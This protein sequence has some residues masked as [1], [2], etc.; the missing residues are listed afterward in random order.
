MAE[1]SNSRLLYLL[2]NRSELWR[3]PQA[4][5]WYVENL[6]EWGKERFYEC[7]N[8]ARSRTDPDQ[9]VVLD[10]DQ[11]LNFIMRSFFEPMKGI[12]GE[13]SV[14]G[15]TILLN[16]K[17]D[18]GVQLI[19]K[20]DRGTREGKLR[21]ALTYHEYKAGLRINRLR[22]IYPN[23]VHT[24]RLFSIPRPLIVPGYSR[25]QFL[26]HNVFA[27]YTEK[28]LIPVLVQEYVNDHNSSTLRHYI[29]T[30]SLEMYIQVVHQMLQLC[31]LLT[32]EDIVHGDLHA[33]NILVQSESIC[34]STSFLEPTDYSM[35]CRII[36]YGGMVWKDEDG[37]VAPPRGQ[38]IPS[39]KKLI[40][41][42]DI[43]RLL[44]SMYSVIEF[45]L[46][47]MHKRR[48]KSAV[49]VKKLLKRKSEI[50]EEVFRLIYPGEDLAEVIAGEKKL[51][52]DDK[53]PESD[54]EWVLE[55]IKKIYRA[56][57]R[58]GRQINDY[59]QRCIGYLDQLMDKN[60]ELTGPPKHGGS[61][62]GYDNHTGEN[63]RSLWYWIFQY[64]SRVKVPGIEFDTLRA[65]MLRGPLPKLKL[66][67]DVLDN[68][69]KLPDIQRLDD[70]PVTTIPF[71]LDEQT[72]N[73][74]EGIDLSQLLQVVMFASGEPIGATPKQLH[75]IRDTD[76]R[77]M[78]MISELNGGYV[79]LTDDEAS[80]P[81]NLNLLW[82]LEDDGQQQHGEDEHGPQVTNDRIRQ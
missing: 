26:V 5:I 2:A 73:L 76:L 41:D 12:V 68:I 23:F 7:F 74:L 32:Q 21:S 71:I 30:A 63:I 58:R 69:G 1:E 28:S 79:T 14:F 49:E 50:I 56:D 54:K 34:L 17:T 31:M 11:V 35:L 47:G 25:G 20:V 46:R 45:E 6:F 57:M 4:C 15:Y 60:I 9:L 53:V 82:Y 55:E 27:D 40:V 77:I 81:R 64:P 13:A 62:S 16:S 59:Y 48:G 66:S 18:N 22:S 75:Q 80:D 3:T 67:D 78:D 29:I 37:L 33:G 36:D 39:R 70:E 42:S 72:R 51:T 52:V 43:R 10:D 44:L 19:V 65:Q 38:W 8:V 61:V 24:F